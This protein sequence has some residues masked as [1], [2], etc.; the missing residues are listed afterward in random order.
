MLVLFPPTL[1]STGDITL[2]VPF[3]ICAPPLSELF[4]VAGHVSFLLF[5]QLRLVFLPVDLHPRSD[6]QSVP[7]P[8][9]IRNRLCSL[10]VSSPPATHT[11]SVSRSF[12]FESHWLARPI[13]AGF[14]KEDV[15]IGI[16]IKRRVE[17]N[18]IDAGIGEFFR[19]P[20][21]AKVIA[22]VKP[23]H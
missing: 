4:P 15:I 2:P 17:I 22:E 7:L 21:P 12:L 3:V 19:V 20:E 10:R 18:E 9:S 16:R 23:V 13:A 14:A 11:L 5:V 1:V 8:A 6:L